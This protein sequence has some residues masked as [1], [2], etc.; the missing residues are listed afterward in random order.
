MTAAVAISTYLVYQI[1]GTAD[2][3][4]WNDSESALNRKEQ[5]EL[6]AEKERDAKA[7]ETRENGDN[8]TV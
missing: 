5:E 6:I 1:F 8:E 3:Q 2:V 4:P 7:T